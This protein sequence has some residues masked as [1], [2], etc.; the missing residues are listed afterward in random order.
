M[1]RDPAA[2]AEAPRPRRRLRR[3][4]L[5]LAVALGAV[6]VVYAGL[7]G[8]TVASFSPLDPG[9][10][11]P[12]PLPPEVA[13]RFS[14]PEAGTPPVVVA[15]FG[16]E[17]GRGWRSRWVQ[18]EVT[19]PGD[20]QPHKVQLI[21]HAPTDDGPARRPAIVI[22]PILGGRNDVAI[23]AARG[24]A[25]RGLHGVVVLRAES[26]LDGAADEARLERVLRTAI[27]DRR[28][29]ID[30]LEAQ[31]DVDASRIGA[32]G[33][34]LGGV[35]TTVLAAVEPRVRASVIA[36]GGGDLADVIV[37]S[38]ERRMQRYV[39]ERVAAAGGDAEALRRRIAAAVVSDPLT[40]APHVDARRA[41]V[42]TARWDQ[43]VPGDA[44][45]RL[46]VA[47]GRPARYALPTGHYSAA[48]LTP[49]ILGT[50]LDW[51]EAQLGP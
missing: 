12:A 19:T 49:L 16:H 14:Y 15:E 45:E 26:L 31:P 42:W 47:L 33:V 51:L 7:A 43:V 3:A 8:S 6:V 37:R 39:E 35:V 29:A 36:L 48:V 2:P 9:Y 10:A 40:L 23:I 18:V 34:S 25:R 27:V 44:Q 30:W 21:H 4:L 41:L 28:R 1:S 17:S 11:G 46:H 20:A 5:V 22:T 13:A 24:A 32:L 50:S 38:G